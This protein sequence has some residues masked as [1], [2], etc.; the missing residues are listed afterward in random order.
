MQHSIVFPVIISTSMYLKLK[1]VEFLFDFQTK[2]FI[3]GLWINVNWWYKCVIPSDK[4][5]SLNIFIIWNKGRIL[6]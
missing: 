6:L 2:M 1:S 3:T 4:N 5:F